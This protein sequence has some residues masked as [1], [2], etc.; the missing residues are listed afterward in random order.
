MQVR[1]LV[2]GYAGEIIDMPYAVARDCIAAGTAVV[3]DD[4][5]APVVRAEIP[6]DWQSLHWFKLRALAKKLT[7]EMP[8]S[9]ADARIAIRNHIAGHD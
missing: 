4:V 2:G 3:I 9:I 7:G 6:S 5:P 8:A 1:Q